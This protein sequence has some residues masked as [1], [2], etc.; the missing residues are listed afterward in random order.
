M[1]YLF[2]GPCQNQKDRNQTGGIVVLFENW[3]RECSN[4]HINYK[5]I[6]SNK[7]NYRSI[8]IAYIQIVKQIYQQS[9]EVDIIMMHGTV[10]DY[11]Y[12]GPIIRKIA[13]YR[14][15]KYALRKFA[16]NFDDNYNSAFCFKKYSL[17]K[18]INKA[19]R[20]YWET[21]R[22]TAWANSI[23]TNSKWFPNVRQS[24]GL[25]RGNRQYQRKFVFISH[26]SYQKGV[27]DIITAFKQ[28]GN[29]YLLH[30]Y[31]PLKGYHVSELEGHYRGTLQPDEVAATLAK[32][33]VVLLP[34]K[35]KTE[36]YPGILLESLSVGLPAIASNVGGIPEI[37][38]NEVNGVI[39]NTVSPQSIITAIREL[40]SLDYSQ[41]SENALSSFAQFDSKIVTS[42]II[43]DLES[44]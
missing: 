6:D 28:L 31:G 33:D 14:K 16:G 34:T 22:L 25:I 23:F 2:I 39:I 38:Q 12:L 35:I 43:K 3:L 29:D 41:L 26:V 8:F 18:T 27:S 24:I 30:I 9:T 20:S 36:G 21:K 13:S 11:V 44:E 17:N 4:A 5:V 42:Q 19:T 1:K 32:Y 10:K 15:I 37:I 7:S 40:E